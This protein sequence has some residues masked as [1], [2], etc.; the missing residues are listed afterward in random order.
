MGATRPRPGASSHQ[1]GRAAAAVVVAS[2][3]TI[4][5]PAARGGHHGAPP[6]PPKVR[7]IAPLTP[8]AAVLRL[9]YNLVA[10]SDPR[11]AAPAASMRWSER[12]EYM[13]P[14]QDTRAAAESNDESVRLRFE[15][16]KPLL[17]FLGVALAPSR[18]FLSRSVYSRPPQ[19]VLHV[20][21]LHSFRVMIPSKQRHK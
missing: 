16:R 14:P 5:R 11:T 4:V 13:L 10:P 21:D 17:G 2:H 3:T 20:D 9:L 7:R 15:L 12:P 6:S 1:S 8:T 18:S 19:E